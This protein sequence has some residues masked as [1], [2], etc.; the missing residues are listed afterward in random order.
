MVLSRLQGE[1]IEIEAP[2]GMPQWTLKTMS[3]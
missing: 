3:E 1:P 2:Q